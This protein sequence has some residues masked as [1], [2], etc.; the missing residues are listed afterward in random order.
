MT[1]VA[2]IFDMSFLSKTINKQIGILFFMEHNDMQTKL[3]KCASAKQ[4]E[5]CFL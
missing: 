4:L 5:M 3:Y 2:N 1:N